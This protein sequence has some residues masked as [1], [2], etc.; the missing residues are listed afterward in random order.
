MKEVD[1]D[2]RVIFSYVT[3]SRLSNGRSQEVNGFAT[4]RLVKLYMQCTIIK[5]NKSNGI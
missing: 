5:I 2:R 1:I 4:E 3:S